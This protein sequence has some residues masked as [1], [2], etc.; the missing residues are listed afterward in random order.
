MPPLFRNQHV[1]VFTCLI[2]MLG[3]LYRPTIA[4]AGV[5]DQSS[6]TMKAAPIVEGHDDLLSPDKKTRERAFK[7]LYAQILAQGD[8]SFDFLR[9]PDK[10]ISALEKAASSDD[11]D[12]A[13]AATYVIFQFATVGGSRKAAEQRGMDIP[14]SDSFESWFEAYKRFDKFGVNATLA[15][16]A[17]EGEGFVQEHAVL[18]IFT[19]DV[20]SEKN[21]DLIIDTFRSANVED[22]TL[23]WILFGLVLSV[24][25][26]PGSNDMRRPISI[27][28]AKAIHE[29]LSN[30]ELPVRRLA[31]KVLAYSSSQNARDVI[32]EGLISGTSDDVFERSLQILR[33]QNS[34][35]VKHDPRHADV[36]NALDSESRKKAYVDLIQSLQ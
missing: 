35:E 34:A 10:L 15:R 20:M 28:L 4:E 31:A 19:Q 13:G 23:R 7:A 12:S 2:C 18:A 9:D 3:L 11:K 6:P 16:L 5:A 24:S 32:I 17:A 36:I 30:E 14:E 8:I 33:Q 22:E 27:K 21:D 1:I 29:L 26:L 25:D